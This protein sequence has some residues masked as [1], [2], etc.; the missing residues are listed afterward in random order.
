MSRVITTSTTIAAPVARVW[1]VL[2]DFARYPEWNPFVRS[3]KGRASVGETL[4][5]VIQASGLMPQTFRPVVIELQPERSF[6][7]RGSLPIP[8]LFTGEHRFEVSPASGWVRFEQSEYFSGILV[9]LLGSV[10]RGTEV[11]FKSMN[12]ALK[13]RAEAI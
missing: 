1:G 13:T 6:A 12:E 4:E 5:V 9:P 2:M 7:W 11:G 3:I 8:G 10:L